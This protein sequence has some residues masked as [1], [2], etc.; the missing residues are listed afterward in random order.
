MNWPHGCYINTVY[1]PFAILSSNLFLIFLISNANFKP[2]SAHNLKKLGYLTS[3]LQNI[4]Q[5]L[6]FRSFFYMAI[7]A[8]Y[9]FLLK[10]IVIS[11]NYTLINQ[12]G[13]IFVT[14]KNQC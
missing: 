3:L 11:N 13:I 7:P 5:H 8:V 10:Y 14:I 1:F 2:E 6:I 12:L 9:V 4:R